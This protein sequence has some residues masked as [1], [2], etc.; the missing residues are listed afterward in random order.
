MLQDLMG[1]TGGGVLVFDFVF[2]F[3]FVCI[4]AFVFVVDFVN[5]IFSHRRDPTGSSFWVFGSKTSVQ[6]G[7]EIYS[8]T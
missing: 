6:A 4:F 8:C 7:G 5:A 2:V 1:D 3:E